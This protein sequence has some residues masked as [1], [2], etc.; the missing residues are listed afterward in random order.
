MEPEYDGP[1]IYNMDL[2]I[3]DIHLLYHCVC[4]RLETWEGSPARHPTEQEH[5]WY[6]KSELYKA[7]LDYKFYDM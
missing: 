2:T 4:K 5:L 7:V 1:A 3:E 6:L